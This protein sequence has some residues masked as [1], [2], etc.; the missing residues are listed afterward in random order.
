[1]WYEPLYPLKFP[2]VLP[3]QAAVTTVTSEVH[4]HICLC[5]MRPLMEIKLE[6][7]TFK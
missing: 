2:G 1:M 7:R 5:K 6:Y 4:Q 3:F